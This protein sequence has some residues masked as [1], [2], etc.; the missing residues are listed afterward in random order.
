MRERLYS[1]R[2]EVRFESKGSRRLILLLCLA[3]ALAFNAWP[4]IM[5]ANEVDVLASAMSCDLEQIENSEESRFTCQLWRNVWKPNRFDGVNFDGAFFHAVSVT[6]E[7]M[8]MSPKTNTAGDFSATNSLSKSFGK[9]HE[10][11]Y[12]ERIPEQ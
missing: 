6:N 10:R 5:E 12:Y 8:R 1:P 7:N 4:H 11:S 2:Q 3:R 9:Y